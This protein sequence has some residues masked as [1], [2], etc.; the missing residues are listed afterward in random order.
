MGKKVK[1]LLCL[2]GV[3]TSKSIRGK[4][5]GGPV[6]KSRGTE[7]L[8]VHDTVKQSV[9]RAPEVIKHS[10]GALVSVASA[11]VGLDDL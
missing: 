6:G 7:N 1:L 11:K 4:Q 3:R 9:E 5:G 8:G 2:G 10:P